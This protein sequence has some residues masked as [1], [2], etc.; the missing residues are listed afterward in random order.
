MNLNNILPSFWL[1]HFKFVVERDRSKLVLPKEDDDIFTDD[2]IPEEDDRTPEDNNATS[3]ALRM[4]PGGYE[5]GPPE[6]PS[7]GD[8]EPDPLESE[9]GFGVIGA[10][11]RSK[12]SDTTTFPYR[13]I[14]QV[15]YD[16]A[17]TGGCTATM[18]SRN[19][20]L[21]AAHCVFDYDAG[22]FKNATQISPGRYRSDGT[23]YDPYG[24]WYVAEKLV[25]Q[26]Y[27]EDE[28][29]N[30]DIGV[31]KL[32]P[33]TINGCEHTYPGDVVGY[34]DISKP[35]IDDSRLSNSRVTGYPGDKSLGEM[36][37]SGQCSPGW[38]TAEANYGFHFCDTYGGNSG[39]SILTTDGQSLGVH[40]QWF[41]GES[42][43]NGACLMHGWMY[44]DIFKLS[45]RGSNLPSCVAPSVPVTALVF[46]LFVYRILN[47]GT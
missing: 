19:T 47:V 10:D 3:R 9:R 15:D 43:Y 29:R 46:F 23:I 4:T 17:R 24:I 20:A 16:Y 6:D 45:G 27:A 22:T 30:H 2:S 13:A 12:V 14:A 40:S 26:S 34:L 35:S 8:A 7:Y 25:F 31:I 11:T 32:Y 41:H 21:T 28:N 39:S 36:W 37:T 33:K 38:N 5:Y 1:L 18:I 44:D 42:V